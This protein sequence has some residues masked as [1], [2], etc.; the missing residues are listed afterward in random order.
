MARY[1]G[2][3]LWRLAWSDQA[4]LQTIPAWDGRLATV[5]TPDAT[6]L[7]SLTVT[8]DEAALATAVRRL[9]WRV[10]VTNQP[11]TVWPLDRAVPADRDEYLVERC[12]GRRKG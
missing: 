5:Q 3:G 9:G 8:M 2:E 1:Q 12:C 11:A 7:P 4:P 6:P 10:Y